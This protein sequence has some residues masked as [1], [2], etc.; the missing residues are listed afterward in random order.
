[1]SRRSSRSS[2]LFAPRITSTAPPESPLMYSARRRFAMWICATPRLCFAITRCRPFVFRSASIWESWMF[3]RLYD[4]IACESCESRSWT[5]AS[6][7]CACWRFE[8]IDG[9][10]VAEPLVNTSIAT[11]VVASTRATA[12]RIPGRFTPLPL[13]LRNGA[14]MVG[15]PATSAGA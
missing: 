11:A 13:G 8:P 10:A 1:M 12:C 5:W 6:T 7:A 2:R 4:S 9:S 15:S 14:P 3:A